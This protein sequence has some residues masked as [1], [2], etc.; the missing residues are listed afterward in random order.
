MSRAKIN[1]FL[2]RAKKISIDAE[3]LGKSLSPVG[4]KRASTTLPQSFQMKSPS[5]VSYQKTSPSPSSFHRSFISSSEDS[6]K[7]ATKKVLATKSFGV[8][9]KSISP[10]FRKAMAD[11]KQSPEIQNNS[12]KL[13]V[14]IERIAKDKGKF[15]KEIEQN[16]KN[17]DSAAENLI[18]NLHLQKKLLSQNPNIKVIEEKY[19]NQFNKLWNYLKQKL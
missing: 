4:V 16:G 13:E 8:K 19:K 15:C 14:I 18:T 3:R 10:N 2:M 6:P 1:E 17:E 11:I 7:S 5:P 12:R 9:N